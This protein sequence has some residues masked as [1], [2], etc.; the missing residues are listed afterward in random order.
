MPFPY[1]VQV[2]ERET[3]RPIAY[4]VCVSLPDAH[5]EYARFNRL[6]MEDCDI[7][8]SRMTAATVRLY[9]KF[10]GKG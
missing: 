7:D 4:A 8:I 6:F 9:C 2:T 5:D 3:R 10:R 1:I